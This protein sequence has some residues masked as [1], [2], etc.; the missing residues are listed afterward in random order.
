MTIDSIRPMLEKREREILAP[1]AALSANSRGRARAESPC[2]MRTAYQR[3][4]DRILYSKSFRRLQDKTQ[5]FPGG[6]RDQ[7]RSRLTHTLEVAQVARSL[8]KCLCLNE[9]LTEAIALAHD[10]GHAPYGHAGESA[11]NRIVPGGFKHYKQSLRVV[12]VLEKMNLTRE[13]RDGIL[14]HS[15]S[16]SFAINYIDPGRPSTLE[17]QVVRISDKVAYLNHDL[18]DAVNAKI[19]QPDDLPVRVQKNLGT[20]SSERINAMI[21]DVVETSM[22][23][24]LVAIGM[25]VE[26]AEIV[27]DLKRFM[28]KE[29]YPKG[30]SDKDREVVDMQIPELYEYFLCRPDRLPAEH[31]TPVL[32]RGI[33]D[34]IAGMTDSVFRD[35]VKRVL[36]A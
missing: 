3:D 30:L 5:V 8:S 34:Y 1:Q 27:L 18:E 33:A 32:T 2:A 25:S 22:K 35:T 11:L 9:D 16:G 28:Y 29:V 14:K 20:S 19:I 13:V 24:D 12:D 4:R 31:Q 36:N 15:R 7:Y 26:M 10:L 6:S 23:K 17:G 21:R